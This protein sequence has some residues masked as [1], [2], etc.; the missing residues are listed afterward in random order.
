MRFATL[1][2]A[3]APMIAGCNQFSSTK[4]A[5]FELRD[6]TTKEETTPATEYSEEWN[7]FKSTGTLL[8]QGVPTDK[9]VI[10]ML[11]VKDTSDSPNPE[12]QYT[13]VLVRGGTGKVEIS[14]SDY[15]KVSKRPNYQW[16]VLGWQEMQSGSIKV[17]N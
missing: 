6:F 9:A 13:S 2:L 8:A 3:I 14:K 7:S 1:V 10:V 17:I 4:N 11:E 5:T 15:G 16:S 12:S